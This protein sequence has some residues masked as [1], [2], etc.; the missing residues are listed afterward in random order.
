MLSRAG[1][2]DVVEVIVLPSGSATMA[3]ELG[4]PSGESTRIHS[5]NLRKQFSHSDYEA[6]KNNAN[7]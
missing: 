3:F 6:L 5:S 2:D 1:F 7:R 4:E